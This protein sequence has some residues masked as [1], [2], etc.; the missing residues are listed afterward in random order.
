MLRKRATMDSASGKPN[1]D[2][3]GILDFIKQKRIAESGPGTTPQKILSPTSIKSPTYS[4]KKFILDELWDNTDDQ[5]LE[6]AGDRIYMEVIDK[7]YLDNMRTLVA[8]QNVSYANVE[9]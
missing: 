7:E 2:M 9:N 6:R 3:G 1:N 4:K 5:H 8:K